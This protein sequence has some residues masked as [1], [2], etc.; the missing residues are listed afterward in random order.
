MHRL[1]LT[2]VFMALSLIAPLSHAGTCPANTDCVP[3][4]HTRWC[5]RLPVHCDQSTPAPFFCP[6]LGSIPAQHGVRSYT[7][8]LNDTITA[9]T[10]PSSC[11]T[12]YA[13]GTIGTDATPET[14]G[15]GVGGVFGP[16]SCT[17]TVNLNMVQPDGLVQVLVVGAGKQRS[18]FCP[19]GFTPGPNSCERP[20]VACC[21][22]TKH[23]VLPFAQEKRLSATDFTGA[24][25]LDW[26][27]YYNSQSRHSRHSLEIESTTLLGPHWATNWE[28]RLDVQSV[29]SLRVLRPDGTQTQFSLTAGLWTAWKGEPVT[30]TAISGAPAGSPAWLYRDQQNRLEAFASD[31]RLLYIEY[32]DG[33]RFDLSYNATNRLQRITARDGRSLNLIW[34]TFYEGVN[35][36]FV[37]LT[38]VQFPDGHEVSYSYNA[39]NVGT[40]RLV[41]VFDAIGT[42]ATYLYNDTGSTFT[43]VDKDYLITGILDPAGQ[44]Y[45]TYKY[46]NQRQSD[47]IGLDRRCS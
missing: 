13:S 12:G 26:V 39:G 11:G 31:G 14:C 36:V 41:S 16:T 29:D 21:D 43:G 20:R 42:R 4:L 30:L 32:L 34:N 28:A 2:F 45:S 9:Y 46:D 1:Y 5:H 18:P 10:T 7:E 17:K 19:S 47:R 37:R 27:R 44:R 40:S 22:L 3:Y 8:Q 24:G 23:P 35:P 38:K 33:R 25:G 6:E 15:G